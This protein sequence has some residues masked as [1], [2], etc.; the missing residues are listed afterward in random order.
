MNAL[1]NNLSNYKGVQ[2]NKSLLNEY[3]RYGYDDRKEFKMDIKYICKD[4]NIE[5]VDNK[6]FEDKEKRN[7]QVK[8]RKN[9][10]DYYKKCIITGSII[11]ECEAAHIIP[12]KDGGK[13]ELTNGLLLSSNL[14]KTFD[15]YYWS[16]N[17]RTSCIEVLND[18]SGLILLYKNKKV[19]ISNNTLLHIQYH[20]DIFTKKL[21]ND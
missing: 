13:Y 9:L 5:I 10:I 14:H 7:D 15:L 16:I 6:K 18:E 2:I 19:D 3:K 12:V 4:N 8:F 17:P 20:Y 1:I 11:E 21:K